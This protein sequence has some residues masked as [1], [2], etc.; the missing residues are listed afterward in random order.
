[1]P[2]TI[3][4]TRRTAATGREAEIWSLS[5]DEAYLHALLRDIFET[6][7]ENIVFGPI[8]EGGAFE[9]RCPGPPKSVT[10]FDG[11]LTVHFGATHFH[12]CI[13]E[14]KGSSENPTPEA[15]KRRRRTAR[16][17]IFRE[18]DEDGCA[19]TWGLRL[20]NGHDEQLITIFF[21]NPFLTDADGLAETPDWSRLATWEAIGRAYLGRGLDGADRSGKG[22]R[23]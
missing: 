11:Y 15:L 16:A 14:N 6:H 8:I 13:G 2:A 5:T 7:W 18:F 4:S 23:S 12:L 17:E 10:L 22:F 19:L 21:P 1:M 3:S 20:F 9:F